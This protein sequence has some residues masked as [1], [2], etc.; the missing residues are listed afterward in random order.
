MPNVTNAGGHIESRMEPNNYAEVDTATAIGERDTILA[1]WVITLKA[2]PTR[3]N[4]ANHERLRYYS[5]GTTSPNSGSYLPVAQ[6]D[7]PCEYRC[8]GPMPA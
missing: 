2:P 1:A 6:M 3:R 4:F 7:G 8:T 5:K